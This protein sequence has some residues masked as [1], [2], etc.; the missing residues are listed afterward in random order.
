[1]T[2][3][4]LDLHKVK[5]EDSSNIKKLLKDCNH[6]WEDKEEDKSD[7]KPKGY[8]IFTY[9]GNHYELVTYNKKRLFNSFS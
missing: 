7:Y 1:M 5:L 2:L 9:S 3:P 6:T 4:Y 8:I